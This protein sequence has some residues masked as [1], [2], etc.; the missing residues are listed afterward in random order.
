MILT[1]TL[2]AVTSPGSPTTI[3]PILTLI[4]TIT[5]SATTSTDPRFFGWGSVEGDFLSGTLVYMSLN[6]E[7]TYKPSLHHLDSIGSCEAGSTFSD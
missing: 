6:I 4:P 5:A 2:Q 1:S 7:V 3:A